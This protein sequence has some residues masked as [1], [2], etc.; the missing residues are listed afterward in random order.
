MV[1]YKTVSV[2]VV[3]N[4]DVSCMYKFPMTRG[5]ENEAIRSA[6]L[7]TM[8]LIFFSLKVDLFSLRVTSSR[9]GCRHDPGIVSALI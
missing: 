8:V 4:A 3:A 6:V 7:M 9:C 2:S 5:Y 1:S